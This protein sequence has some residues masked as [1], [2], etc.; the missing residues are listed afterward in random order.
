LGENFGHVI[1]E[2]LGAGCPVVISDQTPWSHLQEKGV[3]WTLP[4]DDLSGW[5]QALQSCVDM[6][7]AAFTEMSERA[8]RFAREFVELP[9][10]RE[11]Y[12][13]LFTHAI[14]LTERT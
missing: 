10:T 3:G 8:R 13:D 6:E 1:L 2:A 11:E 5:R 12:I 14:S 9:G 4:L 7:N